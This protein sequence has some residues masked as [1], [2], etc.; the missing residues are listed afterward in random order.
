[1]NKN[2]TKAEVNTF[3]THIISL[4]SNPEKVKNDKLGAFEMQ[5][6]VLCLRGHGS[7]SPIHEVHI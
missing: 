4:L 5:F 2:E 6:F 3:S 1:M 7:E